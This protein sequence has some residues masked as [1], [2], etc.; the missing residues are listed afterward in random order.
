MNHKPSEVIASQIAPNDGAT[1]QVGGRRRSIAQIMNPKP[2][3]LPRVVHLMR[4]AALTL[5]AQD[6]V[7]PV[8][9]EMV[10][11]LLRGGTGAASISRKLAVIADS[12]A[13]DPH[14]EAACRDVRAALELL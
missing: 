9:R 4:C 6:P 2:V 3:D 10:V 14:A 1:L 11:E 5:S 13:L 8:L 12:L 7:T